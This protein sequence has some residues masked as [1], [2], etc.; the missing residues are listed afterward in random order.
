[1]PRAEER[2]IFTQERIESLR[3]MLWEVL[4]ELDDLQKQMATFQERRERSEAL[5]DDFI[6]D[7]SEVWDH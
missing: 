3:S 2:K 4:H 7:M 5:F 6:F 1:M